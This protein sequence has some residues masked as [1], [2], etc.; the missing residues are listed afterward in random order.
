M[1]G[2]VFLCGTDGAGQEIIKWIDILSLLGLRRLHK[3]NQST[4][5]GCVGP[6]FIR[7]LLRRG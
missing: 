6:M 4:D 2:T 5:H 7:V 3:H 1:Y